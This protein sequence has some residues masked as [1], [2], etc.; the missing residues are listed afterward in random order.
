MSCGNIIVPEVENDPCNGCQ[1][2]DEC[3]TVSAD[4]TYLGITEPTDLKTVIE[5]LIL[6]IEELENDG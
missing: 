1:T 6:K 2:K 4:L 3:V 5:A